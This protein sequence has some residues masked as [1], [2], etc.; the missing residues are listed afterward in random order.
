MQADG[1]GS[2]ESYPAN[3]V[4]NKY[5]YGSFLMIY[6]YI[7]LSFFNFWYFER[8]NQRFIKA[9]ILQFCKTIRESSR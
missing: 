1:A 4:L 2:R 7:L 3:D 6:L 9:V 5:I 8:V